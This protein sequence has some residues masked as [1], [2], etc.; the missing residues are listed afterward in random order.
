MKTYLIPLIL[1]LGLNFSGIGQVIAYED[2]IN[3]PPTHKDTHSAGTS[4][5]NNVTFNT[6]CVNPVPTITV[7]TTQ[8]TV[9]IQP[10]RVVTTGDTIHVPIHLT[11][12]TIHSMEFFITYD[13]T[14]LGSHAT[15][16][17][18]VHPAFTVTAFNQAYDP[19]TLYI[20]I[21]ADGLTNV[22]FT[23]EKVVDLVF[24]MTSTGSTAM[25]FRKAPEA[26]PVSGIFDE[27]GIPV[28]VV[29]YTD[30]LITV[31][32]PVVPAE[33]T[34]QGVTI[35][36]GQTNCYNASQTIY[37]AGSGTSFVV[38]SGGSA[39]MIAGQR[40]FYYPGTTV[41]SGGYMR[42]YI[43]PTG[44]W[45][46]TMA[47][48]IATVVT[49]KEELT[50][51][52]DQNRFKV[53]PNPTTGNLTIEQTGEKISELV[54]IEVYSMLGNLVFKIENISERKQGFNLHDLPVGLYFL[55]IHN[56][57]RSETIK[58]VKQ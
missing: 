13:H 28:T 42:G 10:D 36:S 39:T 44:P 26:A 47:P 2:F 45:C 17:T 24:T 23:G 43:A 52:L 50:A 25:H 58:I 49:G 6:L 19:A 40:L 38:Q 22:I 31:N 14:I 15:P 7:T 34:V 30:N 37:I 51:I 53:Y 5:R 48:S 27:N 1:I 33:I 9:T 8:A 3:S 16:Y 21:E 35:G 4:N 32:P 12:Q 29:T 20:L 18:A 46:G 56:G 57:D 41:Q 55:R 11:G 54:K